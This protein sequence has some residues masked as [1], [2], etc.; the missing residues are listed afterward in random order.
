MMFNDSYSASGSFICT[1]ME[2]IKVL[3]EKYE[4]D[5]EKF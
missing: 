2:T 1:Q 4:E 5:K 3:R